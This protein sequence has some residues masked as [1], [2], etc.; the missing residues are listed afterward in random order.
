MALGRLVVPEEKNTAP[1]S[2]DFTVA[3]AASTSAGGTAPPRRMKLSH[4]S[5]ASSRP[6]MGSI[7]TNRRRNGNRADSS[8]PGSAVRMAG[9]NSD[10]VSPKSFFR[11]WPSNN[12]MDTP[13]TLSR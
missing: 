13:E 5:T 12:S 6:G 4:V 1:V 9:S 2:E 11:T 7:L 10:N 8:R 3:A